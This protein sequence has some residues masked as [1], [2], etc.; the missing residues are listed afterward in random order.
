MTKATCGR[1][2]YCHIA[3]SGVRAQDHHDAEHDIRYDI[4]TIAESLHFDPQSER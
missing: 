3:I 4:G 1:T 2:N